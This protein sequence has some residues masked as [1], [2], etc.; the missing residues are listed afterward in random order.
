M[1][2]PDTAQDDLPAIQRSALDGTGGGPVRGLTVGGRVVLADAAVSASP[3]VTR[4]LITHELVHVAQQRRLGAAMPAPGTA[5][6]ARLESDARTAE[7]RAAWEELLLAPT[8]PAPPTPDASGSPAPGGAGRSAGDA[9]S[10]PA[11]LQRVFSAGFGAPVQAAE[12]DAP[13]PAPS[14]DAPEGGA[15]SLAAMSDRDIEE[16]LRR[17]YPRL[18]NHL[19]AEL[20]IARERVGT[21]VDYR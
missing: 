3:A 4:P 11:H 17:L 2:L 12:G 15:G 6:A 7:S 19:A 21:L 8:S 5:T 18:R 1:S 14:P 9:F 13:A 20:L 10:V 16:L